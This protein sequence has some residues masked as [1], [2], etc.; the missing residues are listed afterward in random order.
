MKTKKV[1]TV[2]GMEV[3]TNIIVVIISQYTCG[4]NHHAL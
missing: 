2:K 3:V 1:I 4:S